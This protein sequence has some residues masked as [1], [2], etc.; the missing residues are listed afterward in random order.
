M[1]LAGRMA[2]LGTEAVFEVGAKARALEAQGREVIHLEIGEPDFDTPEHVTAAGIEALRAGQTHYAAPEGLAPLREAIAAQVSRTRGIPVSPAE[3]IVTPGAK[4]I[5]FYTLLALAEA[6]DEVIYPDPGFPI[7]ESMI[8]FV[9]AKAVPAPLREENDFR[10]DVDELCRKV[11]PRTRLIILN[12]P[13]NPTG[14]VLSQRDLEAI[15]TVARQHDLMILSDEIYARILYAGEPLSIASFPGLKERTIIMDGFSKIHAMTG[16]RLGYGVMPEEL[17]QHMRR[18]MINSNSCTATFTQHA[19]VE[20]LRGPQEAQTRMVA[21]FRERRDA[22]VAGLR[23]IPG[24]TCREPQ[25]AFYVFPNISGYGLSSQDFADYILQRAGVAV[26]AGTA[27]GRYGEG[28]VRISYAN[29]LANIER[30][31]ERMAEAIAEL[32][33]P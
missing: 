16:W 1:K 21:A 4:P 13:E 32:G 29:S 25:G 5:I 20:A 11:T 10:I 19:G 2:R 15:A 9:G 31:L 14:S 7:Y 12:S 8:D 33:R 22:L 3:V 6:G 28:Y 17:A 18:L 30:A 23:R 27:F 24:I 26:V